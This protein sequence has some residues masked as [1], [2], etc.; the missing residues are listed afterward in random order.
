MKTRI[1]AGTIVLATAMLLPGASR[2]A[3]C[4]E[5]V[6]RLAAGYGMAVPRT[7]LGGRGD[8]RATGSG[9]SAAETPLTTESRGIAAAPDTAPPGVQAER[10]APAEAPAGS[11]T[12]APPPAA[13]GAQE[14]PTALPSLD[15]LPAA[16]APEL[17]GR[18]AAALGAARAAE[19]EGDSETCWRR[20]REAQALAAEQAGQR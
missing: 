12:S 5:E 3:T 17:R 6:D 2:A 15:P 14:A 13:S 16:P 18:V 11:G 9:P 8:E 7:D 4:V 19:A 20:L 1:V 10:A